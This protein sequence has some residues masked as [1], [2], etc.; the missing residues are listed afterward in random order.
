[1]E[2][3]RDRIVELLREEGEGERA[4]R[5]ERELPEV[6]DIERDAGLLEGLG[7][8]PKEVLQK[9]SGEGIPKLS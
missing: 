7:L 6:V 4:A 3:N 1:M 2:V 8:D 9:I 5:A